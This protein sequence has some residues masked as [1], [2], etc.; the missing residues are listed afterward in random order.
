M[1]TKK[2]VIQVTR[3]YH[4]IAAVS[5]EV[6]SEMTRKDISDFIA[7]DTDTNNRIDEALASVS[8]SGGEDEYEF[9]AE[10]E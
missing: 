6:D 7:F 10:T 3:T 8:L 9:I 1:A 4:K 5:I 2:V